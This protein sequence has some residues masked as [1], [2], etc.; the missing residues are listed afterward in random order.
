MNFEIQWRGRWQWRNRRDSSSSIEKKKEER[1]E[2]EQTSLSLSL[3][4]AAIPPDAF[5]RPSPALACGCHTGGCLSAG[6]TLS[7]G[8]G[9]HAIL[10]HGSSS[11]PLGQESI[12]IFIYIF[13][14]ID[15]YRWT[16]LMRTLLLCSPFFFGAGSTSKNSDSLSHSA[17]N[18][19]SFL[20][21]VE[22]KQKKAKNRSG[23]TRES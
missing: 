8:S 9:A 3:S 6:G 18:F 2:G 22:V 13:I 5:L 14:S 20:K 21:G 15:L 12:D 7:G 19:F 23:E 11:R 16:N 10:P 4:L 1:E 17:N